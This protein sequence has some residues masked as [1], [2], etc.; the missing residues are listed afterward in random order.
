[1]KH[2][3]DVI[4]ESR[5]ANPN[6]VGGLIHLSMEMLK[7]RAK[8]EMLHVPFRGTAPALTA[9]AAGDVQVSMAGYA[10]AGGLIEAGRLKPIAV[11]SPERVSAL[12]NIPNP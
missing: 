3:E 12:P 9:L 2:G 10:T 7:H 8:V 1:L 4:W 11:A 6:T 5:T